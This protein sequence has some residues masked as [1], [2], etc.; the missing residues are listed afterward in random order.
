MK[1][2]DIPGIDNKTGIARYGD[3]LEIYLSVLR[4]FVADAESVSE[5]LGRVTHVTEE[6]LP[7]YSIKA[8]GLKG[9]SACVGAE[10]L[11]E[12]AAALESLAKAGD[13][14]GVLAGHGELLQ[15]VREL[16]A[17]VTGWLREYDGENEKT[18]LPEP[19]EAVL[20]RLKKSCEAFDIGEIDAAMDELE[21]FDYET[22]GELIAWLKEKIANSDFP[23]AAAHLARLLQ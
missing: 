3:D 13:F 7:D 2:I 19:G 21:R 16:V 6:T 10:G 17:A 11:R 20:V 22:G 8:H 23:E 5:G 12:K 15:S 4:S 18:R 1:I 14:E 9:I